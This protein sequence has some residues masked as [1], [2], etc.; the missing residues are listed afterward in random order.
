[1]RESMTRM[2][3]VGWTTYTFLMFFLYLKIKPVNSLN[4][5][6]HES[7]YHSSS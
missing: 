7:V 2:K 5:L 3:L 1:M 4:E 6:S